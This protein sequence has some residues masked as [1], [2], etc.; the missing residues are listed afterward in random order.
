MSMKISPEIAGSAAYLTTVAGSMLKKGYEG[1]NGERYQDEFFAPLVADVGQSILD[2]FA[3]WALTH[4]AMTNR[5]RKGAVVGLALELLNHGWGAYRKSNGGASSAIFA[6]KLENRF[7][8]NENGQ[9]TLADLAKEADEKDKNTPKKPEQPV[10]K[11]ANNTTVPNNTNTNQEATKT[12]KTPTPE[13]PVKKTTTKA[14]PTT[15][16]SNQT[17]ELYT[18]NGKIPARTYWKEATNDK[19]EAM[20][21]TADFKRSLQ[22]YANTNLSQA[23]KERRAAADV[24]EWNRRKQRKGQQKQSTTPT[25]TSPNDKLPLH[26]TP[27]GETGRDIYRGSKIIGL[28]KDG[29]PIIETPRAKSGD[30]T[31]ADTVKSKD[32]LESVTGWSKEE[33]K[34]FLDD[35]KTFKDLRSR[36]NRIYINEEDPTD[37]LKTRHAT[38]RDYLA[39]VRSH[40]EALGEDRQENIMLGKFSKDPEAQKQWQKVIDD[41]WG[42]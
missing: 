12:D 19:I 34:R 41:T 14:T 37:T 23:E 32:T 8:Q 28:A 17:G 7:F 38:K 39:Y 30:K 15:R 4:G 33:M 16:V 26:P 2:G 11:P 6:D 24:I 42:L 1:I 27:D 31:L 13:A 40:P 35:E 18:V 21:N 9:K 10:A 22:D 3:A 29:S 5:K 25:K 20:R 36:D